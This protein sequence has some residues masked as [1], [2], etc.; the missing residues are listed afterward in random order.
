MSVDLL[1]WAPLTQARASG[2][3]CRPARLTPDSVRGTQSEEDTEKCPVNA[4]LKSMDQSASGKVP[5]KVTS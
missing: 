5:H 4:M 1:P 2:G 3:L